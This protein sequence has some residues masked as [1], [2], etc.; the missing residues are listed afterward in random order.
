M[1]TLKEQ[2]DELE[3]CLAEC[4]HSKT[5]DELYRHSMREFFTWM[6]H[7]LM[8][9]DQ[10]TLLAV[11]RWM[12]KKGWSNSTQ[13]TCAAAVRLYICW[14]FKGRHPLVRLQVRREDPGPQR[15]LTAAQ[16]KLLMA[17]LI[18]ENQTGV[19]KCHL[20]TRNQA[21]IALMV[22]T[23]IRA[24]SLTHLTLDKI[25]MDEKR[26]FVLGKGHKWYPVV[27]SETTRQLLERWLE[28]RSWYA[29]D[30]VKELFVA[31]RGLQSGQPLTTAGLRMLFRRMGEEAGI[32]LISPHDMRRTFAT[33][34]FRN[35]AP[36]R[37]VQIQ[38]G[39]TDLKLVERYS[40]ALTCD[41]FAP[42][43]PIEALGR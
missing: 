35:G 15:T 28:I 21:M 36:S 1:Q 18:P 34:S 14:K 11:R 40:A 22:D 8:D 38:G 3:N 30:E 29:P 32:G 13:H 19:S 10:V 9:L 25:Q 12:D 31:I 37:Q 33:L 16:L 5:T 39:W 23:G 27:F 42:Y 2:L 6:N 4:R 41:D 24:A 43:S 7:E 17:S 20:A 26:A